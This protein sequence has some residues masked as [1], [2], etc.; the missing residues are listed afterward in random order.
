MT[1]P[2]IS[3]GISFKN[4]KPYFQLAVQS[5]FA[6]TF[7]D[8][9]LLLVDDGSTDG[10]IEFAQSLDDPRVRV[11][12]D[13]W[14]RN[15]NVRL[16]QMVREARGRYFFRMDADD[17]MHPG[18]LARQLTVLESSRENTV[19]GSTCYSIDANSRVVGSREGVSEQKQGFPARHS[20]IHPTVAAPTQWFRRNAYSESFLFHRSQDAE[21]WCRTTA[22]TR[23][24]IIPEPL[25]Y[26]RELGTFSF[27][28]YL[29]TSLGIVYLCHMHATN[30]FEYCYL[31]SRELSKCWFTSLMFG[32]GASDLVIRRR[33]AKVSES[34][35]QQ[36]EQGLE[37]VKCQEL[38]V[39]KAKLLRIG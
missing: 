23:F 39:R 26:Y 21:L 19:V 36:A 28:N 20:F 5:V 18:R 29:G 6:Q 14:N 27:Q 38:P 10:S 3:I 15:L 17:V 34:I 35:R 24:H 31:L 22:S 4:P 16:N 1:A 12:A 8:W 33:Y 9:E 2:L 25:L 30:R 11:I 37:V 13:G 32:L 7:S